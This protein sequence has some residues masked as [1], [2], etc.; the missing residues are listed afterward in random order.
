MSPTVLNTIRSVFLTTLALCCAACA[1]P[2]PSSSLLP[3]PRPTDP[4]SASTDD[5]VLAE[6]RARPLALA[7]IDVTHGCP[8]TQPQPVQGSTLSALGSE[9]LFAGGL[10]PSTIGMKHSASMAIHT[11]R[12]IGSANRTIRARFSSEAPSF[13]RGVPVAFR[14]ADG[15]PAAELWL[16][17]QPPA[18]PRTSVRT[19]G[20]GSPMSVSLQSAA[21]ACRSK[22][23]VTSVGTPSCSKSIDTTRTLTSSYS[24]A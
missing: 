1:G 5:P 24:W 21:T 12:F 4:A 13:G 2:D 9:P 19:F 20:R 17:T 6:L 3:S 23:S 14:S 18:K 7:E 8:V 11:S 16:T 10:G 22:G 15:L